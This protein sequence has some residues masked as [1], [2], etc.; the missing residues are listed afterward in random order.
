M[1]SKADIEEM[2]RRVKEIVEK[3]VED[4]ESDEIIDAMEATLEWV[5][6]EQLPDEHVED[7]FVDVD[8]D[9]EDSDDSDGDDDDDEDEHVIVG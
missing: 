6:D 1:R 5:L 7:H 2:M 9:D 4:G 8:D 3:A